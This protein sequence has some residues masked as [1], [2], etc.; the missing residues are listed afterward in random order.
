MLKH[1]SLFQLIFFLLLHHMFLSLNL[2][3]ARTSQIIFFHLINHILYSVRTSFHYS[4]YGMI[5]GSKLG[6]NI[7]TRCRPDIQIVV[8]TLSS[9]SHIVQLSWSLVH[10]IILIVTIFVFHLLSS[11]NPLVRCLP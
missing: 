11:C 9:Y 6:T 8:V 10:S 1:N 2:H 7:L 4:C 3:P 5:F